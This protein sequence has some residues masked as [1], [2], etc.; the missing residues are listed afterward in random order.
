MSLRPFTSLLV[1]ALALGVYA[2]PAGAQIFIGNA[3]T[4]AVDEYGFDGS[5][6]AA[7][8]TPSN[9]PVGLAVS[10]TSLYVVGGP[11][12][13]VYT[14]AGGFN[15]SLAPQL[16]A[17]DFIAVSGNTLYAD[18][19]T[20]GNIESYSTAT[21]SLIN[22]SVTSDNYDPA[23]LAVTANGSVFLGSNGFVSE[24]GG[25]QT[26]AP[27]NVGAVAATLATSGNDLYV[28]NGSA[29][30]EYD[31]TTG[32]MVSGF[33]LTGV[34]D[35]GVTGVTGLAVYGG[36]LYT[37]DF[38]TGTVA[39]YDAVTGALIN[40]ALITGLVGAESIAVGGIAGSLTPVP[41][42]IWAGVAALVPIAGVVWQRRRSRAAAGVVA[43]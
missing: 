39:E 8:F 1:A 40:S 16:G 2:C 11:A 5:G 30:N 10:G 18:D 32:Q 19:W 35:T 29:I 15:G 12:V 27:Y 14:A 20:L 22:P 7:L 43:A 9:S 13:G 4:G 34:A 41:E 21:G 31:A 23:V 37:L 25:N 26:F 42:P 17:T 3:T 33:S 28:L 36:D 24:V 6:G 38:S